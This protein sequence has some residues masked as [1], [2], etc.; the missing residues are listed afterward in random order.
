MRKNKQM[1]LNTF[2]P[3]SLAARITSSRLSSLALIV[4][5]L[6]V[7]ITALILHI[8]LVHADAPEIMNLTA[9][10]TYYSEVTDPFAQTIRWAGIKVIH[11]AIELSEGTLP[12][13]S[14][15]ITAPGVVQA[16]F[17]GAN[18]DDGFHD[19]I[20]TQ[21]S[22]FNIAS[23]E[24]ITP[25]DLLSDHLFNRTEYPQFYTNFTL[26]TGDNYYGKSDNPNATFCCNMTTILVGA[27]NIS[28]FQVNL[29]Y[30]YTYYLGKYN[31]HGKQVPLFIAPHQ[32]TLCYNSTVCYA[33][34]LIP[35]SPSVSWSFFSINSLGAY[36]FDVYVDS[37]LTTIIPQTAKPYNITLRASNLYT[38]AVAAFTPVAIGEEDGQN[39]FVP[40]RL[41]GYVSRAYTVG[42]SDI[43]GFESFISTPTIYPLVAGSNY[44]FFVAA[45]I[46][47]TPTSIQSI[48][49]ASANKLLFGSK[50]VSPQSVFDNAKT[51]VNAMDQITSYLYRWTSVLEQAKTINI[52]YDV[53]YQNYTIDREPGSFNDFT[54]ETGIPYVVSF[55]VLNFSN[56]TATDPNL[57][58]T[59]G[60]FQQQGGYLVLNPYTDSA[61]LNS[62]TRIDE[63]TVPAG[64][65]LI[66]VPTALGAITSNI[67][68]YVKDVNLRSIGVINATVIP[69][70]SNSED[71]VPYSNDLLKTVTNAINQV[72]HSLYIA[73]NT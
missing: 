35:I 33:Q 48:S 14:S 49:V 17:P 7:L 30:G 65:Q 28:V 62:T 34:F 39:L 26:T 5:T 38:G 54:L 19:Y 6:S 32:Q 13:L 15:T 47:N 45:I 64:G 1:E 12:F 37:V 25:T 72:L 50:H 31:S 68:F 18:H 2:L 3:Y 51:S 71:G 29:N 23:L 9:G 57:T 58:T 10:E 60:Y 21:D 36:T 24:N 55:N 61:P 66:I 44:S 46:A 63:W 53:G 56:S 16:A 67:S 41:S 22:V 69:S 27:V 11:N 52:T 42:E 20:A 8:P 73:L 43:N 70:L 4:I 59:Y 40:Y